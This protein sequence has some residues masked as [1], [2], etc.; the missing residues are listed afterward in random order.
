[1]IVKLVRAKEPQIL[2]VGSTFMGRKLAPIVAAKLKTGLTAH[3]IDLVLDG[4]NVLDQ[5]IPA[6]GRLLHIQCPK[7]RPQMATVAIGV[8][9]TPKLDHSRRG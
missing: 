1:M 9:P 2:F 5:K 3:C 7:D 4:N 6:Y 8:F